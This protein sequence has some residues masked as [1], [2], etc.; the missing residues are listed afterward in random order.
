MRAQTLLALLAAVIVVVGVPSFVEARTWTKTTGEKIEGEFVK[1]ER[2]VV[3]LRTSDGTEVTVRMPHLSDED[4]KYIREHGEAKPKTKAGDEANRAAQPAPAANEEESKRGGKKRHRKQKDDGS[5]VAVKVMPEPPEKPSSDQPKTMIVE[6]K[7]S[8]NDRDEALKDAFREAVRKVVG[9]YVE[10][11]TVVKNDQVIKDQVLTY[12]GGCVKTHGILSEDSNG[13]IVQVTIWA[14][15]EQDKVVKRLK[16]ASVSVKAVAGGKIWDE[17]QSKRWKDKEAADLLRSVLKGFPDNCMEAKVVGQP[18]HA[19]KGG[20]IELIVDV[21]FSI[22]EAAFEAFRDRLMVVLNHIAEDS[23]DLLIQFREWGDEFKLQDGLNLNVNPKDHTLLFVN[24][25]RNE[26]WTRLGWRV[27]RLDKSLQPV[28]A[29]A[30]GRTGECILTASDKSGR[31]QPI[32]TFSL[33][34]GS[35][36]FSPLVGLTGS[37]FFLSSTFISNKYDLRHSPEIPWEEEIEMTENELKNL[38]KIKC[39]LRFSE[40]EASRR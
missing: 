22:Q 35:D 17:I 30:G 13:G 31:S 25:S 20:K 36:R 16:A 29:E 18:K 3:T 11:E 23:K 32:A 6:A 8:G 37:I 19:D 27:F 33:R 38:T 15:V 24:T 10:Q 7:G 9:A 12:S 28:L 26:L 34:D 4:Q 2:A 40:G 5:A 1:K 14:L 39:E 21:D